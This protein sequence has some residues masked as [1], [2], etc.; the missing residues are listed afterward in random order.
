M[1][2]LILRCY[3]LRTPPVVV[4]QSDMLPE[5]LAY[6][7]SVGPSSCAGLVIARTSD[8]GNFRSR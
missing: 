3:V 5:K 7:V 4:L 6:T 8:G 2:R 1:L